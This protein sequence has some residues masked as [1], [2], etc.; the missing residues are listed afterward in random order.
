VT[1][2]KLITFMKRFDSDDACR[3]HLESVRWPHGP[4]CPHCGAV[5]NAKP[6]GGRPSW[7]CCHACGK[8]FSVTVGTPM[9]GSHLPLRVWYLA[10]YLI[11]ASSKG[12]SS[13]KL[14]Q[15]LG[16]GQKTAWFIGHRIRAMLDSGDETPLSGIVEVDESYIGGKRRNARKGTPSRGRGRGT[17]KPMLF[18]A[19]ER[20]GR[21]RTAPIPSA[22]A[23]AI[24]PLLFAWLN[25]DG[26]LATDE[27]AVY[28][29]FGGKMRRHVVVNHA[30]REFVRWV[31][32]IK[33]HTNTCEGFFGLFKRAIV[34]VWHWISAKHL[35]RYATEHE[36]RWNRRGDVAD[37][38]ARCLIGRHGRLR[39]R[40]LVV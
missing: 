6:V 16:V 35:H 12:I 13:V 24:D 2:M 1:Q 10:L 27:L 25:R 21:A 9:H 4:T 31:H 15:H 11:L 33:A 26:V 29:W 3:A 7:H 22:S 32:G 17:N 28:Q 23:E 36:F 14:G 8:Q 38:I 34:G 37:R 40:E 5:D 39:W 20:G 30:R 18:A 19:I